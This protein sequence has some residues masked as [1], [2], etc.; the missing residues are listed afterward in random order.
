MTLD[1]LAKN[2]EL[3]T[4]LPREILLELYRRVG[5]LEVDLRAQLLVSTHL[6]APAPVTNRLVDVPEA[7]KIL[8][9][10]QDW[11]YRHQDEL[12]VVRQGRSVKFSLAGLDTYIRRRQGRR[13]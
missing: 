1:E 13:L 12:P 2:P 7:A 5:R 8:N 9:C 3:V 4:E 10:S 6:E 11:I